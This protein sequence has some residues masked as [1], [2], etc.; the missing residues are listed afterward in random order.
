M[1]DLIFFEKTSGAKHGLS[2]LAVVLLSL[3]AMLPEARAQA[4]STF[5]ST[6]PQQADLYLTDGRLIDNLGQIHYTVKGN[7]VFLG[8][9]DRKKD[10]LLLVAST[11]FFSRSRGKIHKGNMRRVLY[12]V[13]EGGIYT[14]DEIAEGHANKIAYFE[15][16][17]DN[18][19]ILKKAMT[20]SVL[21]EIH[22]ARPAPAEFAAIFY[23]FN[24]TQ[25]L[26]RAARTR[27]QEALAAEMGDSEGTIKP[28][29]G[30]HIQNEWT[31][32]GE[33]LKPRWGFRPEDEWYFDGET[34]RP[35]Y[36]PRMDEEWLWDGQTLKNA[37]RNGPRDEWVWE[38]DILKPYWEPDIDDQWKLQGDV[39][40]PYWGHN[41]DR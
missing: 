33:I 7:I 24:E 37:W 41:P 26:E 4:D 14:G 20:D 25:Q 5:V 16:E 10:I 9:G 18:R 35:L 34:L 15:K 19:F 13:L 6:P 28:Y 29:W 11:N 2:C 39:V 32:D 38:G 17:K 21:A 27:Q 3:A 31:W 22:G 23:Y 40:K 8:E 12:S 1:M 30:S 36:N